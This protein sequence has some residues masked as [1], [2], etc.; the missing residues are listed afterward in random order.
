MTARF[1]SSRL[2][3]VSVFVCLP[4]CL[5]VVYFVC[6][7]C[8]FQVNRIASFGDFFPPKSEELFKMNPSWLHMVI[9]VSL[10]FFFSLITT[11]AL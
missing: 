8:G 4:A 9:Q 1:P 11:A 5:Q 3:G 10:Q 2:F 6:V 7:C